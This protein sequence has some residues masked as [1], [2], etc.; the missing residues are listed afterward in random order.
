M[1]RSLTDIINSI[2]SDKNSRP[3]LN[4]LNSTSKAAIWR[5]W[6]SVAATAQQNLEIIQDR[7]EADVNEIIANNFIGTAQWYAERSRE[8][9]LGYDLTLNGTRFSYS[10]AD[11]ES[12]I[13][14]AVSVTE[15]TGST[16]FIKVAK[17]DDSANLIALTPTEKTQFSR[18]ITKIKL[19]GT[20]INIISLASDELVMSGCTVYYDSIY[21]PATIKASVETAL[22]DYTKAIPF[23]GKV[24][25]NDVIDTIQ[26][27]TGVN[28]VEV[29]NLAIK[30]GFD[31]VPVN[32]IIELPSGYI[33]ECTDEG[34]TFSDLI[35]YV[36]V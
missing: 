9:Q 28:D 8:F 16:L 14:K 35:T 30:S 34:L 22:R 2:L 17:E 24:K 20:K 36:G 13:I 7:F 23:D 25:L 18:Y 6:V 5:N 3:E 12:L 11:A 32:R 29:N 21:D 10:V 19:A 26:N 15:S 1:A 4:S 33:N 31:I 27:V